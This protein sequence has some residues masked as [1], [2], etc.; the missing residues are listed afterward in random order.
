MITSS[1]DRYII[2]YNKYYYIYYVIILTD[3]YRCSIESSLSGRITAW[4]GSCHAA[5][6]SPPGCGEDRGARHRVPSPLWARPRLR[7]TTGN[8]NRLKPHMLRTV[9]CFALLLLAG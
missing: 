4:Y 5:D 2:I 8:H 7:K 6:P 9:S 1:S 3:F